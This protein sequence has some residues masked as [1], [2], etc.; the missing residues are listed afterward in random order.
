MIVFLLKSGLHFILFFCPL[1]SYATLW[2]NE[3]KKKDFM[4]YRKTGSEDSLI[5]VVNNYE[6]SRTG[7]GKF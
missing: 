7:G 3:E 2:K 1:K 5:A 6:D 4:D